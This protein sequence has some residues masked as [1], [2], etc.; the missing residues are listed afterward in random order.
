MLEAR[1]LVNGEGGVGG[2]G[3]R[4]GDLAH[5]HL[6]ILGFSCGQHPR[7]EIHLVTEVLT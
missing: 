4:E 3:G 2:L 7:L 6:A 5:P 1:S